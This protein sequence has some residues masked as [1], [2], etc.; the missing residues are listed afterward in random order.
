MK[1]KFTATV[2]FPTYHEPENSWKN[3]EVREVPDEKGAYLLKTFPGIFTEENPAEKMVEKAE[4]KMVTG[5][6][7]KKF[8]KKKGKK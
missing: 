4:N 8:G 3:G 1:V 6:E 2:G 7:T 5:G